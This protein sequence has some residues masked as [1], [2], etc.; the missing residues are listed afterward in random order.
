MNSIDFDSFDSM[1]PSIES[2]ESIPTHFPE[3]CCFCTNDISLT[4]DNYCSICNGPYKIYI[5]KK[6]DIIY[7]SPFEYFIHNIEYKKI[8]EFFNNL[9]NVNESFECVFDEFESKSIVKYK[10][11]DDTLEVV[12]Y[13]QYDMNQDNK[14]YYVLKIHFL[15]RTHLRDL[16]KIHLIFNGKIDFL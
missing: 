2:E 14:I 12:V 7:S 10:K 15:T 1:I 4:S 11:E 9:P 5:A 6:S 16:L 3:Q 13:I 8:K